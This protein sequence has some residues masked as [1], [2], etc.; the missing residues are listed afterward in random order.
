[1]AY[2]IDRLTDH[3]Y[4]LL[5]TK[6]VGIAYMLFADTVESRTCNV[7]LTLAS[8]SYG[9]DEAY[10][11]FEKEQWAISLFNFGA[12]NLMALI[13]QVL[14][15]VNQGTDLQN[16]VELAAYLGGHLNNE[17]VDWPQHGIDSVTQH[18]NIH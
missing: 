4:M 6:H 5:D 7:Q 16:P 12:D 18:R 17:T 13:T 3:T 9:P 2:Q 11:I 14:T 8:I 15:H 1:M 10:V